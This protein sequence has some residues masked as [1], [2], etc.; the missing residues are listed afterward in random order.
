MRLSRLILGIN[1]IKTD[2]FT[3]TEISSVTADSRACRRGSVFVALRGSHLNGEDFVWDAYRRGARVF[4]AEGKI[5][6][7][8]RTTVIYSNNARKTL[9]ELSSRLCGNP[10]K[11]LLF[12]GITGTKGKTTTAYLV[13]KILS[14]SGIKSI[15]VGTLGVL[16]YPAYATVNT[17]PDPTVLFPLF[18]SAVRSGIRACVLEVSSQALKDFRVWG[19]SF[20]C[21]A[22]TGLGRDHIGDFEHPSFCDYIRSKRS[23][24]S[25][26]GAKRAI[27]NFD[28][29]YASY[30]SAGIPRV[31]TCGFTRGSDILISDFSDTERGAEFLVDNVRVSTRLP[32]AYNARNAALALAI[33]R[34]LVG[35]SLSCGA[36]HIRSVKVPGRFDLKS[37]GERRVVI[38][39]AHNRESLKE[40]ITLSRRLFHGRIICVFGSVGGRSLNRRHELAEAAEKYADFSVITTD[41]PG[42]EYPLSVCAEIYGAFRDKSRAK[43]IISR[44]EAIKYALSIAGEGDAVLLLGRGHEAYMNVGGESIAFSDAEYIDKINK[45][46]A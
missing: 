35:I 11:K 2:E 28:D 23:L 46:L 24:F 17:T 16:G 27:V 29:P 6:S 5:P 41:N 7:I 4:V 44:A 21:V 20:D 33:A 32:G 26:Y 13:S 12:V 8:P 36:K 25:S 19:I 9:A 30:V 40:I 39:Y 14:E 45:G 38:D 43:I 34:E 31:V 18:K 15:C 3:D 1:G 37:A 22:F 10:E 42:C